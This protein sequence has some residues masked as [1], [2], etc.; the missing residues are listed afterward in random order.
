[1]GEKAVM[2]IRL[3]SPLGRYPNADVKIGQSHM[4]IRKDIAFTAV[5]VMPSATHGFGVEHY[6]EIEI[7][8][9]EEIRFLGA[10]TLSLHAEKGMVYA[11]PLPLEK[12]LPLARPEE[13][14]KLWDAQSLLIEA[15]AL[16]DAV[17][18]RWRTHGAILPPRMGGPPYMIH[19]ADLDLDVFALLHRDVELTNWLALRGLGTL[20]RADMLFTRPELAEAALMMI[21]VALEASLGLIWEKLKSAGNSAPTAMD[22]GRYLDSVFNPHL[23]TGKYFESSYEDR[24]KI[25]HPA[26]RFGV[27]AFPPASY[28]NYYDL[29]QDLH[30]VYAHLL[31]GKIWPV[32]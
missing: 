10:L 26:S 15:R 24:I 9:A 13:P 18:E 12:N 4:I 6:S 19:G 27:F 14:T 5:V 21:F 16:A 30:S 28:D 31:V 32:L 8:A 3:M 29:R 25:M 1:M 2:R 23:E 22:A 20:V 17:P 7:L 11:Y